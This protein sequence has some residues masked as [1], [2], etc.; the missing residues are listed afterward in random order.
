MEVLLDGADDG[1]VLGLD[2]LSRSWGGLGQGRLVIPIDQALRVWGKTTIPKLEALCVLEQIM[3]SS[4]E[5]FKDNGYH[6]CL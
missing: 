4:S 5:L 2:L 1:A 6:E 3:K